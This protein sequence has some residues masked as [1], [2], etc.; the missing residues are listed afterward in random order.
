MV[1]GKKGWPEEFSVNLFY[2][3]EKEMS[4][5]G[6]LTFFANKLPLMSIFLPSHQVMELQWFFFHFSFSVAL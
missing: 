3:K 5:F 6:I 2:I 1:Y 4:F